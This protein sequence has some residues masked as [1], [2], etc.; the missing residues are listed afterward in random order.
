M[1]QSVYSKH[2]PLVW[3]ALFL[4]AFFYYFYTHDL[5]RTITFLADQLHNSKHFIIDTDGSLKPA[6]PKT[7]KKKSTPAT[8]IT[9]KTVDDLLNQLKT[10]KGYITLFT[11]DDN[12][13][14]IL[15]KLIQE[16]K[17]K[18]SI[19]IFS[20]TD[21]IIV[22]AL[23]DACKRKVQVEVITDKNCL[24]DRYGKIDDLYHAGVKVY[25]YNPNYY[26]KKKPGLMH[27]KF[28]VF[29]NNYT[30]KGLV[31][32]GSY[33]FTKSAHTYNQENVLILN[34]KGI[35]SRYLR[36]FERIKERSDVYKPFLT[37]HAQIKK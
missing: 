29:S 34:R 12:T 2:S 37:P 18:I 11:P 23:H 26:N 7:P 25:V 32:T 10:K 6:L 17:E 24:V 33:N 30:G 3:T 19:A 14:D 5:N 8:P 16:E 1:K 28:M 4:S 13:Y 27:H 21:S 15:L 9:N 31:W 22:Q 20:F 35:V 36:Q